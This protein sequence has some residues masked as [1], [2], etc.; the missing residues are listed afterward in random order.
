VREAYPEFSK[1]TALERITEARAAGAQALVSA[2]PWCERNFMDA[3]AG[4]RDGM[5]VLDVVDLVQ[6]AL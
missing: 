3:L 2:C 6:R 4:T 5:Q 1:W